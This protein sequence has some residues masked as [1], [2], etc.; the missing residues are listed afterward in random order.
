MPPPP[1]TS[2]TD[3]SGDDEEED[4][5]PTT[6]AAGGRCGGVS[7]AGGG[8]DSLFRAEA[9]GTQAGQVGRATA[10][11][12]SFRARRASFVPSVSQSEARLSDTGSDE[13]LDAKRC[14]QGGNSGHGQC[15]RGSTISQARM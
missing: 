1:P 9:A 15:K 5:I 2:P 4:S 10:S 3:R 6:L 8:H 7:S 13:R 12:L 14:P 11:S